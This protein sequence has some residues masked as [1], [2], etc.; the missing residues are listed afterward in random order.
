MKKFL[1]SASLASAVF[2]SASAQTI[3]IENKTVSKFE[4]KTI[5][6]NF[7]KSDDALYT[8]YQF[9]VELPSGFELTIDDSNVSGKNIT[10]NTASIGTNTYRVVGFNSAPDDD[11]DLSG[12]LATLNVKALRSTNGGQTYVIKV[13]NIH[14]AKIVLDE[15]NG[16]DVQDV[17]VDDY[18]QT[19][20]L[21]ADK[22]IEFT[23]VRPTES[24]A[25]QLENAGL[26]SDDLITSVKVDRTIKA[27]TWSTLVL[28]FNMN[29]DE[30]TR[31]FGD[32][33]QIADFKTWDA[34]TE[35]NDVKSINITLSQQEDDLY[36]KANRPCFIK[37]S[38]AIESIIVYDKKVDAS[39]ENPT[40]T[41]PMKSESAVEGKMIGYYKNSTIPAK[42]LFASGNSWYYSVGKT[43]TKAFRA[44]FYL[45]KILNSYYTDNTSSAKISLVFDDES[46][47]GIAGVETEKAEGNNKV[48]NL[49][50]Q[51]VGDSL[52]SLPAGLYIQNGKKVLVK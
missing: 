33:V 38:Q 30:I 13:S 35:G 14:L 25:Q 41:A 23:E 2:A 22:T 45:N 48:Y 18:T 5:D 10:L 51:N 9:D 28:P 26:S 8:A 17:A 11:Y 3:S 29:E 32:D 20:K 1:L 37:T 44:A 52:E 49:S 39:E 43:T 47:T 16:D 27:N 31:N 34:V 46:T 19:M 21:E 12:V 15:T 42:Y 36:I 6:I 40:I 24:V 7:S 4:T 50:G